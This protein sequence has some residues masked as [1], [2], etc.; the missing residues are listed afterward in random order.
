M[1]LCWKCQAALKEGASFCGACGAKAAGPGGA[2]PPPQA[3]AAGTTPRPAAPPPGATPRPGAAYLAGS[4]TT[5]RTGPPK[6]TGQQQVYTALAFLFV[7][8][9]L[10]FA[11]WNLQKYLSR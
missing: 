6:K 3:A 2:T 8:I 10:G 4:A 5:R 9:L 11:G 1:N 7:A